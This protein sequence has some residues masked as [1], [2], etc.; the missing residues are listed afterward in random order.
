MKDNSALLLHPIRIRIVQLLAYNKSMT[1][2]SLADAM[3]DVPRSTIYRHVSVLQD[4]DILTVVK[5]EKIR[6]TYEREYALNID[7]V[8]DQEGHLEEQISAMLLKLFSDCSNYFKS[9][10][11]RPVQDKLFLSIN[12]LMLSDD[13][14]EEFKD[15]IYEVVKKRLSFRAEKGRKTRNISIISSPCNTAEIT[16]E[17]SV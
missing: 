17:G 14:F 15:E 3:A 9:P 8:Y 16:E 6:G 12:S 1:V 5:E 7:N 2:S 13:E 11:P 10:D 4:N